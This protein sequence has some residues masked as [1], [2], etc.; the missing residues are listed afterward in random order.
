MDSYDFLMNKL[1]EAL[2]LQIPNM[3]SRVR[4]LKIKYLYDK[5]I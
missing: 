4:K 3:R 1:E 5:R 2:R